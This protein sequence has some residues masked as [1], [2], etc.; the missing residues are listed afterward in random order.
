[1]AD[2]L[3]AGARFVLNQSFFHNPSSFR[4]RLWRYGRS[5]KDAP[6]IFHDREKIS[7]LYRTKKEEKVRVETQKLNKLHLSRS[8]VKADLMHSETLPTDTPS[9][10][11]ISC[12]ESPR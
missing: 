10:F 6:C 11:A 1:M 3:P 12:M 9:L 7:I 5:I 8:A 4:C 2:C